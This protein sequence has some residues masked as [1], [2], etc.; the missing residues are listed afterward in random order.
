VLAD[1][2]IVAELGP[3]DP[4]DVLAAMEQVGAR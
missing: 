4:H 1:G 2:R 3:S